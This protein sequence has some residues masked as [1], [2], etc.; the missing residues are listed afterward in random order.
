M[1]ETKKA[2]EPASFSVKVTALMPS[3]ALKGSG[4]FGGVARA[5]GRSRR[6]RKEEETHALLLKLLFF[7]L[8]DSLIYENYC[9]YLS[10]PTTLTT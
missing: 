9:Y 5:D 2:P 1:N 7:Q 3:R 4:V 10:S 6:T 8:T